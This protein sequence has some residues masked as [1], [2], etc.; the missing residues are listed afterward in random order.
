MKEYIII[1]AGGSGNRMGSSIPKQFL[2]LNSKP[3]LIHTLERLSRFIP[4]A[5]F[6]V[7][8]P[9]SQFEYWKELCEKHYLTINHH[10]SKGGETRFESVKNA[11][12]FVKEEGVV[13][14]HDGVRPLISQEV[15]RKCM[16]T[17]KA[18]GSAIPTLD[19]IESVRQLKD[20][21]SIVVNRSNYKI[22][23]TPQC[24]KSDTILKAYELNYNESF[25][26]DAS[27]V[28][29]IGEKII[30]IDGNK[31]NIKITTPEDLK[32]AEMYLK[33]SD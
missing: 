33:S 7:A 5:E 25:T 27:V 9:E 8:L 2:E 1:V 3:I 26:D 18:E 13:A 19:V 21:T 24:F 20:D 12:A 10:L 4:N 22:V 29:A 30:L 28:E 14:I 32:I 17:A 11:L 6:I 16:A 15:L 23:Q 31:E